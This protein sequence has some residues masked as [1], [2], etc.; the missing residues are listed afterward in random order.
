MESM[1]RFDP[2]CDEARPVEV[3]I[4]GADQG[5]YSVKL[6]PELSLIRLFS[7][8]VFVLRHYT[9]LAQLRDAAEDLA[10]WSFKKG[11]LSVR[12]MEDWDPEFNR[13]PMKKITQKG[14]K[15]PGMGVKKK[16][17]GGGAAGNSEGGV[18]GII[19]S[20]V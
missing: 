11:E 2:S 7:G 3:E 1:L 18:G 4:D 8:Y 14:G 6:S 12:E 19:Y 17:R 10:M 15:R 9:S 13:I 5:I 16:G 20:G